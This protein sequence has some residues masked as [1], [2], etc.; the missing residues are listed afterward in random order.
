MKNKLIIAILLLFAILLIVV[1]IG[2]INMLQ[3]DKAEKKL[4]N[5]EKINKLQMNWFET[6][7]QY[8]EILNSLDK[9]S[10]IVKLAKDDIAQIMLNNLEDIKADLE[11]N[12][13]NNEMEE[14][15]QNGN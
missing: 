10:S 8:L 3:Q 9:S 5:Q 6:M 4:N 11:N 2:L 13:E 12:N 15:S 1:I 7:K 14:K